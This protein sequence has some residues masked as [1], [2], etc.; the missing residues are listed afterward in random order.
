M[1]CPPIDSK[2]ALLGYVITDLNDIELAISVVD[3]PALIHE[4]EQDRT[5]LIKE[6]IE[7]SNRCIILLEAYMQDCKEQNL[8]PYINY[9]RILRE[10]RRSIK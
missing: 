9:F 8:P 1:N 10:L 3:D 6:L 7:V 2:I 5:A 4:Y